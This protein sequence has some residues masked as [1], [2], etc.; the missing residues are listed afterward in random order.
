MTINIDKKSQISMIL[1]DI[2]IYLKSYNINNIIK[3]EMKTILSEL[4][5]NIQ[6]YTP[7]GV[8]KLQI[9]NEILFINASDHGNGIENMDIALQDGHSL[10]GTLGLGFGSLFRL[11]DEIDIQTSDNGTIIN[12]QKSIR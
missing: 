5:Y 9:D 12:I 6:K 7:E 8:V 2:E 11:S 4:I 10:N 1:G 3:M